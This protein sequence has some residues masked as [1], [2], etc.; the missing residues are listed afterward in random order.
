MANGMAKCGHEKSGVTCCKC[1]FICWEQL[2]FINKFK[3]P[4]WSSIIKGELRAY[5]SQLL[6]LLLASVCVQL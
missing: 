1:C 3:I 2:E 5:V 4:I 6:R